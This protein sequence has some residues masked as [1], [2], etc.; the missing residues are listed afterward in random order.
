[1]AV[2]YDAYTSAFQF[3]GEIGTGAKKLLNANQSINGAYSATGFMGG[4]GATLKNMAGTGLE[5]GMNPWEAVKR[6]HMTA[7]GGANIGAIAGTYLGVSA[8]GRIASG[9]GAYRDRHGRTNII[10]VPFF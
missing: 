3:L 8:A 2:K 10:G 7:E 1:M 6:A 4:M 5:G 9:G